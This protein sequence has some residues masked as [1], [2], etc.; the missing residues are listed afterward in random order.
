MSVLVGRT[1]R[2]LVQGMGK[3]GTFHARGC[4]EYGT[5]VVGGTAPGK[6][7]TTVE[8]FPLFDTADDMT[9]AAAKVVAAA[10]GAR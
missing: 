7:G 6:G 4:R 2:V 5:N 3:H 10:G 1:S 9:T 8:G